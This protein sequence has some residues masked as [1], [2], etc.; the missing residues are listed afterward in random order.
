[1]YY[2]YNLFQMQFFLQI[3][4]T[5][6]AATEVQSLMAKF[7]HSVVAVFLKLL[8]IVIASYL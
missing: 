6:N 1:M 7:Y 4:S 5:F 3:C 2:N 8:V